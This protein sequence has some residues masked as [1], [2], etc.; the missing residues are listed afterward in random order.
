M[1]ANFKEARL[2]YAQ[3]CKEIGDADRSLQYF[4]LALSLEST[5]S[6][7]PAYNYRAILYLSMGRHFDAINDAKRAFEISSTQ[8]SVLALLPNLHLAI[9]QF[10]K[11]EDYFRLL[12]NSYPDN[13]GWFQRQIAY[14]FW[15]KLD[16]DPKTFCPDA[17]IDPRLK[18]GTCR[19]A[20]WRSFMEIPRKRY[21]GDVD[22][23]PLTKPIGVPDVE[24]SKILE[25]HKLIEMLGKISPLTSW[26]QLDAIGFVPNPRQHR[27]FGL[28]VL[29]MAAALRE[30]C[31]LVKLNISAETLTSSSLS[32]S[33][34]SLSSSSSSSSSSLSSAPYSSSSPP[35]SSSSSSAASTSCLAP[36]PK[37]MVTSCGLCIPNALA[38]RKYTYHAPSSSGSRISTLSAISRSSSH[39]F[40]WRDFFDIAV[41]WR[42]VSEP[43]DPVWW[44]GKSS[45]ICC[46]HIKIN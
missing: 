1:D 31:R 8:E 11:A 19:K 37:T 35:S 3:M 41:K 15:S 6:Y 24:D 16:A 17:D 12:L 38:S 25:S 10:S 26:I 42:Q 30:H 7:L 39:I 5:R 14:Y 44:I 9:G 21:Q 27:Q 46:S 32:S 22:V 29:Q 18:E 34:S 23:A 2:N 4:E 43:N 45:Y 36:S 20:N 40:G 28:A 13:I 33:S